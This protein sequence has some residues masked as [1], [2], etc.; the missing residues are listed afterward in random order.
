[1]GI[2]NASKVRY[3]EPLLSFLG[4]DKPLDIFSV[5]YDMAIDSFVIYTKEN[6]Q[7]A[8]IFI[9]TKKILIELMLTYVCTKYMVNS[10]VQNG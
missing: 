1:M 8:S 9:G 2:V 3:L 7:T 4:K 6:T 10:L 5:N